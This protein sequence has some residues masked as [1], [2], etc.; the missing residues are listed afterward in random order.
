MSRSVVFLCQFC[1]FTV[2]AYILLRILVLIRWLPLILADFWWFAMMIDYFNDQI[3]NND[4]I[5]IQNIIKYFYI[6]ESIIKTLAQYVINNIYR[7]IISSNAVCARLVN[8]MCPPI[9]GLCTQVLTQLLHAVTHL[10][11]I[12]CP[13]TCTICGLLIIL[14]G[15]YEFTCIRRHC[16]YHYHFLHYIF[17][18]LV[19]LVW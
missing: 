19:W 6:E 1:V 14:S 13:N 7:W 10:I 16:H 5:V 15:T 12:F 4:F 2:R 8:L 17:K 11:L 3:I 18:Y 9:F